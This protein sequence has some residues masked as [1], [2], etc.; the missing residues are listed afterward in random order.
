VTEACALGKPAIY[1]PLEP[2][3]GDEQNKNARRS[4]DA[5]GA[6]VVKQ[7][8][9]RAETILAALKPLLTDEAS[10]KA[11]GEAARKL[12]T[13]NAAGALAETVLALAGRR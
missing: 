13:P 6:V 7:A 10:R 8:E 5:G 1:I 11:M 2:A 12:A 4:A 3:S 9:C